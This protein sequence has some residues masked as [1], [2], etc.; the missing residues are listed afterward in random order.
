VSL[1]RIL[2]VPFVYRAWKGPFAAKKMSP[3]ARH[4]DLSRLGRVLDIGCGPGTNAS[5]FQGADYVGVDFNPEYIRNAQTRYPGMKFVAADATEYEPAQPFDFILLNSLLHHLDDAQVGTV[6]STARSK[7][8]PSGHVHIIEL[9]TS[10][11][12][13]PGA[14]ARLD[15]G[16]FARPL[17]RWREMFGQHFTEALTEPFT[18]GLAG[19]GMWELVYFKGKPKTN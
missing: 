9:L 19:V 1:T 5:Y 6:L 8:A 11:R 14:L 2:E 12:A 18:V 4:N 16:K 15:R 10:Q 17:E 3:I 13:L 7:L